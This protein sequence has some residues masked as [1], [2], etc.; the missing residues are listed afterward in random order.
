MCAYR[1]PVQTTRCTPLPP[2]GQNA[3][4]SGRRAC[5]VF[6]PPETSELLL[7]LIDS[8][9]GSAFVADWEMRHQFVRYLV[10]ERGWYP[11]TGMWAGQASNPYGVEGYKSLAE[12]ARV[13]FE[14]REGAKGPEATNVVTV[15]A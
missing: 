6:C 13:E 12:G 14:P 1:P 3:T 10:S 7:R 11:A 5:A 9:G 15:A 4:R 2:L 8:F